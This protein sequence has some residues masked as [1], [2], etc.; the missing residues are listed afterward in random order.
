[1]G[2]RVRAVRARDFLRYSTAGV[3]LPVCAFIAMDTVAS[4]LE[5]LAVGPSPAVVTGT[6]S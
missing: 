6:N 4:S 3:L 2:Q 5:V 1:M